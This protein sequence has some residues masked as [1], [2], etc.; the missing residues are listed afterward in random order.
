MT[1]TQEQHTTLDGNVIQKC[2]VIFD[3]FEMGLTGKRQ[4]TFRFL[5]FRYIKT[6]ESVSREDSVF[7][8]DIKQRK[9][10]SA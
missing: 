9:H 3:R 1:E 4:V 5:S 8:Y 10:L 7:R 2:A 6:R